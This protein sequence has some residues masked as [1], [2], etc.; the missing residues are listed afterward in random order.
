MTSALGTTLPILPD[1]STGDLVRVL[2]CRACGLD[3]SL[4]PV[5]CRR[6][7]STDL[8]STNTP[9]A[10][11]V[12]AVTQVHRAPTPALRDLVPYTI[13][14]VDLIGG[15]RLMAR[16]ANG[17]RIGDLVVARIS[18]RGDDANLHFM[19]REKS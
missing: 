9:C 12:Y 15:S 7:G 4:D 17:L 14:L 13:L 10:G 6:C 2:R 1:R 19:R 16:G 5:A 3:Q 8:F 11:V 18:R